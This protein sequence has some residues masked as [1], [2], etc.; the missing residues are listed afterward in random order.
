MCQ[1]P[2]RQDA[3]YHVPLPVSAPHLLSISLCSLA[4]ELTGSLSVSLTQEDH[5]SLRLFALAVS[6]ISAQLTPRHLCLGSKVT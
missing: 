2:N 6:Q 5:G 3:G 4:V 1:A